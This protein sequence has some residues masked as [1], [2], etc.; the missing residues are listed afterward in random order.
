MDEKKKVP[1]VENNEEAIEQP[2]PAPKAP[3][4]KLPLIIGG[5][6][7]GVALITVAVVLILGGGKHKHSYGE[8]NVAEMPTC[9]VAG[10]EERVCECGEKETRPVAA[11]GHTEVMDSAVAPTCTSGGLTEGKHCSE[12]NAVITAQESIPMVAHTYDNKYDENCNICGHKRDAE[13]AHAETQIIPGKPAT[14]NATGLTDGS[15]CQKCGE[16]LVSQVAIPVKPHTEVVDS[17]KA[18]TCTSAG[19]TKGKHCSVCSTVIIAQNIIPASHRYSDKYE[20]NDNY[21]WRK[22]TVC[23]EKNISNHIIDDEAFC[24]ICTHIVSPTS[25]IIYDVSN[26]GTY[27]EVVAY[28]GSAKKIRIADTY[29][30][31]PVKIIYDSAFESNETITSIII[32]DSVISIGDMAFR[33]CSRLTSVVIGDSV[34][35]I[36]DSAFDFCKS[37]SSVIIGDS[38][39]SIGTGTFCY[40]SSLTSVVIPDSVTSI[41]D[42]AFYD[43]SSL[44]DVY[45]TGSMEEW[46]AIAFDSWSNNYLRNATKHYNYVPEN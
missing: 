44:T 7:A 39:T 28:V 22:C 38:V 6:I 45:Y 19:L 30:G 4:P 20:Y 9:T 18:A 17:A 23:D 41:G 31:L 14:C 35:S 26:D 1:E 46:K 24:S 12:C 2:I 37:L 32:P 36:G 43:C 40:C 34:T 25:G 5:A 13:C 33:D 29:E 8:W 10:V 27:A 11:L 15:K 42:Y 21:H 3:I 16:I